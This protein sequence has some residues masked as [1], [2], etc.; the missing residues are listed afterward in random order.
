MIKSAQASRSESTRVTSNKFRRII[1]V[2]LLTLILGL[3]YLA[4]LYTSIIILPATHLSDS[5]TLIAQAW[6][7]I[8]SEF[9]GTLPTTRTRTYAA[10]RGILGSLDDPYSVLIEPPAAQLESD[11]L[12]GE[13]GG[14]AADLRRDAEGRTLL[15]PY[16]DGPAATAGVL[17]SDEL[18]FIDNSAVFPEHTLD[19]IQTRLRGDIGQ[20]L[21]LGLMRGSDQI[22]DVD[23]ELANVAPPSTIWRIIDTAPEVGYLSVRSFTDRT[24]AEVQQAIA[25]LRQHGMDVLILDLRDNGG[26]L[27]QSA[28]D[29]AGQFADGLILIEVYRDGREKTFNAPATGV[30]RDMTLVILINHSTA[31]ASEIVAAALRERQRAILIGETTFGKGSVQNIYS[32]IDGSSLHITTALWFTPELQQFSG[33][34]L[35]PDIEVIRNEEDR[36]SGRDPVLERAIAYLQAQSP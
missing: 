33:Q 20:H 5:D 9:Y 36:V 14:I 24:A 29:V 8:E 13:F 7:L 2:L 18:V 15:S 17:E 10:I 1:G 32:L 35:T 6:E 31:S 34:G 4:G 12:R 26:G 21:R 23:V 28:V 25:D 30:A 11:Q 3:G 16:P 22:F 27:L 19:E